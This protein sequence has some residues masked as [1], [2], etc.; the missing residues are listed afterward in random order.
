M[1]QQVNISGG[2]I[3]GIDKFET[4]V[5]AGARFRGHM[6]GKRQGLSKR[7]ELEWV[8]G[9]YGIPSANADL[10]SATEATNITCDRDFEILGT[11]ATTDDALVYVEGGVQLVTSGSDGDS[12]ILVPHLDANQT[13]WQKVTWGTDQEVEWEALIETGAAITTSIIWAG[14]KLTNTSVAVTDDDQLYFRYEN[15][16]NSG[17]WQAISTSSGTDSISDAGVAAV[18]LATKYHLKITVD[19]ARVARFYINDVL[20]K[21]TSAMDAADLKPYIG[22]EEDGA[23][24]ARTL[25]VYGQSISRSPGA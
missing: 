20:V 22:V 19:D 5:G 17:K 12:C 7:F 18:V 11:N 13:A 2:A 10:V 4:V 23:S 15:G 25:Y 1:G 6:T 24:S 16:V 21:T 14:L 3:A 9:N 8:P